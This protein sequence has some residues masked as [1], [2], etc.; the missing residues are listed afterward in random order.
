MHF[1]DNGATTLN[2]IKYPGKIVIEAPGGQLYRGSESKP[3]PG[4]GLWDMSG[5]ALGWAGQLRFSQTFTL[6]RR[7]SPPVTFRIARNGDEWSFDWDGRLTV[8]LDDFHPVKG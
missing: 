3:L 8:I 1:L 4:D 2:G 5:L 7:T 6:R